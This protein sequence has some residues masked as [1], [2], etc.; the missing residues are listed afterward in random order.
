MDRLS[1]LITERLRLNPA[2]TSDTDA[3]WRLWTL[4]DVRRYMF[5]DVAMPRSEAAEW[6]AWT[7]TLHQRGLGT[8]VVRAKAGDMLGHIALVPANSLAEH[9]RQFAGDIEF[10]IAFFPETWGKG[11]AM[12]AL[13]AVLHHGIRDAGLSRILGVADAP[14]TASRTLQERAGFTYMCEVAWGPHPAIVS[15]YTD[16]PTP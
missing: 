13:K 8:W 16:V 9:D 14:N 3:L 12:E 4:P 11:Y 2:V 6:I 10:G 7:Q 15:A 5:D 1:T